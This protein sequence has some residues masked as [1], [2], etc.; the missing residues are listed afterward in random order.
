MEYKDYYKILGVSRDA[1]EEEIKK[2]YRRLAR[3]YHPDVNKS[4]DAEERFKEI[5]EAYEVLSDPEKRR[6][7]DALG[8][9]WERWQRM[10]G[11]PGG[12]DWGPWVSTPGGQRVRVEYVSPED[13]GDLFGDFG[14]GGGFSEFFEQIFGGM[15]TRT[16]S[17]RTTS[18]R[19]STRTRGRDIEQPVQVT[20][21]EAFH[22][23]RRRIRL[24][25]GTTIEAK[26]PP[27]VYTGS[28]IRLSGRGEPG[29]GGGPAG[30]LYLKVE[31]L[32]HSRFERK[33]DDL[34]IRVP[35]DLYTAI[36]GGEVRVPT[37]EGEVKLTIPPETPNGRTFRLKGQGMPQLKNPRQRGDLYAQVEVE[38][39]RHLSERERELFRQLRDLRGGRQ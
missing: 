7:Y 30:D 2:A 11:T 16:G 5:N 20:L 15:G 32:P 34:Y 27:G 39:P 18:R 37:L 33:G 4:P 24:P 10:G 19:A 8:A 36:L 35:V 25:D 12:F 9:E 3:K 23:T 31:V 14:L 38:L 17:R 22:G 28:R 21:E 1:S 6:K 13:L 29:A 26:I